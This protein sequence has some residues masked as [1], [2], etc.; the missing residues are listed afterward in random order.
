MTKIRI[1]TSG[2]QIA[3][4]LED[5]K[6]ARDFISLLPLTL[7]LEDFNNTEMISDLPR[8]LSSLDAEAGYK[9]VTGDISYFAPWGNLAIFYRDFKFSSGLI[10]LGTIN[11][12]V[13][14]LQ[15]QTSIRIELL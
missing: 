14:L 1:I 3:A 10:K 15:G 11:T 6:T 5:N 13:E 2:Q 12:G 4:T 8:P 9:P 7:S